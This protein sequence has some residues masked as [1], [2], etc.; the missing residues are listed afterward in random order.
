MPIFFWP[1]HKPRAKLKMRETYPHKILS[2][3][4]ASAEDTGPTEDLVHLFLYRYQP[5]VAQAAIGRSKAEAV[6]NLI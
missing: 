5:A 3:L 1:G 6:A 2:L 4:Q